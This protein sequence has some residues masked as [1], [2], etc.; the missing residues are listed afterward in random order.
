MVFNINPLH[1][2][3]GKNRLL[4]LRMRVYSFMPS[5]RRPIVPRVCFCANVFTNPLPINGRTCNTTIN[6]I[7]L[8]LHADSYI[9]RSEVL[10]ALICTV[11]SFED[12]TPCSHVE[13]YRRFGVAY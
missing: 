3:H 4:L 5:N 8:L 9:I 1:G 13:V 7:M 11:L 10:I 2:P 6:I 12:V